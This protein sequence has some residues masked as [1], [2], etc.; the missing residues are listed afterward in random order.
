[1]APSQG[2]AFLTG[3]LSALVLVLLVNILPN[4]TRRSPVLGR[5]VEIGSECSAF[6]HQ[7]GGR[8]TRL[9]T[10][11]CRVPGF[12]CLSGVVPTGFV[13]MGRNLST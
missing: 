10:V 11:S 6:D 9:V 1:M 13:L 12:S 7:V 5:P 3:N 2:T 4:F 8:V